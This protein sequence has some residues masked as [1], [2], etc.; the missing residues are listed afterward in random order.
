MLEGDPVIYETEQGSPEWHR[1]R[2]GKV[3]A[4]MFVEVRKRLKSG[5]N[6]GDYSSAAKDYAF[7]LAVERLSGEP[8]DE[9]FET[10]QMRRGHE[11]EPD[12]RERHAFR[13]RK[14][15]RHAGFITT[16][17]GRFGASGDGLIDPRGGS[18]YKCF[19]SPVSLRKVLYDMDPSDQWDQVQGSL[20]ISGREWWHLC[21]YTPAL[22]SY[23]SDLIVYEAERNE[24]YIGALWADLESFDRLV[25][26]YREHLTT[27]PKTPI[28]M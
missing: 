9:G 17:C 18:E 1:L 26:E 6:K 10:W 19:V 13:I 3:T 20:A 12:A 4:S 24:D 7:R 11:L 21:Y 2:C 14:E 22:A 25:E 16:P 15:I 27:L 28:R 23:G 5:P 8:M